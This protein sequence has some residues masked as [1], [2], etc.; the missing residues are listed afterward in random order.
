MLSTQ[1]RQRMQFICSRI[2]NRAHV[3]LPDMIWANK[4]AAAN[5][6]AATMLRQAQRTAANP[7]MPEEGLDQFLNDLDIGGIGHESQGIRRFDH[8]D[9]IVDFF[10]D[11]NRPD[12]WRQRD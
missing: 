2:A 6:H 10:S 8:P 5:R 12:D 9:Q 1:Y 7:N 11:P 3:E 4:L